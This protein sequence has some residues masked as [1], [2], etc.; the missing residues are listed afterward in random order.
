MFDEN[1]MNHPERLTRIGIF[2]SLPVLQKG[3]LK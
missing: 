1:S 2:E 3:V